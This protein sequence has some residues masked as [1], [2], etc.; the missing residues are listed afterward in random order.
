LGRFSPGFLLGFVFF[1]AF[2]V[3]FV[4][5][6]FF[7]LSLFFFR[8]SP[9]VLFFSR[10]GGGDAFVVLG[11]RA[12][13][14]N[15]VFCLISV[16]AND[17]RRRDARRLGRKRRV[18]VDATASERASTLSAYFIRFASFGQVGVSSFRGFGVE[19]GTR[20]GRRKEPRF[21]F[22]RQN[23]ARRVDFLRRVGYNGASSAVCRDLSAARRRFDRLFPVFV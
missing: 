17:S 20:R 16:A 19:G 13:W 7:T 2:S 14:G 8:L 1:P 4:F 10:R 23:V 12:A 9:F 22:F 15:F 11:A 18:G 21:D 5:L 6:S 3:C